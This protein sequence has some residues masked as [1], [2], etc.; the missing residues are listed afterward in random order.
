[1]PELG[2][3]V[4]VTWDLPADPALAA[5]LWGR[6]REGRVL[7]AEL[8]VEEDALGSLAALAPELS[9]G[10][11]RVSLLAGLPLLPALAGAL[12]A[13]GLRA[14]ELGLLPPFDAPAGDADLSRASAAVWSTPEGLASFPA[15]LDLAGRAGLRTVLLLNPPAPA[16]PLTA[17]DR[18]RAAAAWRASG[19]EGRVALRC[20]DLFLGEALD[21]DPFRGYAGCQAAGFLAHVDRSGR[22]LACRTLPEALGDLTGSALA[23]LWATDRRRALRALLDAAP[24]ACAGCGLEASCRGGCRGLAADLGADPSC[25][26]GGEPTRH[27]R[28][29]TGTDRH[30]PLTGDIA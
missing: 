6:L 29:R 3:P 12:G 22:L 2:A 7:F 23:D 16:A 14:L 9:R 24:S 30:G 4:R 21:L 20:H 15:A 27:R 28:A 18:S 17:A 26:A 19:L 8:R 5:C 10:G 25:P 1:M 13:E 11:P